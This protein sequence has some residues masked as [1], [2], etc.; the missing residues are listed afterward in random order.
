[1]K[2]NKILCAVI[3]LF[4]CGTILTSTV[5]GET[6]LSFASQD[7][8]T[9]WLHNHAIV[10]WT[11]QV[12]KATN[13]EVKIKIYPSQTL[14]KGKDSWNAVASGVVDMAW[15]FHGYWP[16]MTPLSD[17]M[18]LPALPFKTA[19]KGSEIFWRLYEK[20][21]EIQKE[22]STNKV[23]LVFT[24]NPHVLITTKQPIKRLEDFEGMKFRA[25]GGPPTES[26]KLAGA[27]PVMIPMP[28]CYI[29]LQKGVVDGM[30]GPWTAIQAF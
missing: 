2:N 26:I 4:A 29:S 25:T 13:G 5:F 27:T 3:F 23:L 11:K 7:P 18:S 19:E 15:C 14:V 1:M 24:S 28:D 12:E 20:F 22:F 10:P 6:T 17:V 8:A 9:S 30:H 16:G 21:P